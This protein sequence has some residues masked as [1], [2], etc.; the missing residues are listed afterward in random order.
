MWFQLRPVGIEF[1]E[2]A[3]RKWVVEGEVAAPRADVWRHYVDPTTWPS[4]FPGVREAHYRGE[5]PWGVGSIREADIRGFGMVEVMVAWEEG[6]RW[7]YTIERAT[8]PL[9]RAQ[10]E[11]T[12]FEDTP[13][14]TLLR[15]TIAADPGALLTITRPLFQGTVER[16]FGVA[17]RNLEAQLKRG[18][19]A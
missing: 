1:L 11:C 16:L 2:T 18:A 7:A 6:R 9:A 19:R 14:G 3:R 4:W 13:A 10:L 17:L 15:W 8:A 12:E 5:E